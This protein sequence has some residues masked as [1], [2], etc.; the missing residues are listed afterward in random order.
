[1][2]LKVGD[3]I[4]AKP[5]GS[6]TFGD[7]TTTTTV[8]SIIGSKIRISTVAPISGGATI[9]YGG[10]LNVSKFSSTNKTYGYAGSS[11]DNGQIV[12]KIP[13][14]IYNNNNVIQYQ[15]YLTPKTYPPTLDKDSSYGNWLYLSGEL[16][17][18]PTFQI[19]SLDNT[20]DGGS[21][22]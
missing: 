4:K 14:Q 3:L 7:T 2:N 17:T 6:A 13:K 15:Y 16:T 19:S 22:S 11:Q 21:P 10:V 12:I 9:I 8:T 5:D 1:M 18:K 20:I